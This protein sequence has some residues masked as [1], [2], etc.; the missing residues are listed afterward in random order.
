MV[1]SDIKLWRAS[2]NKEYYTYGAY[3]IHGELLY[4]GYGKGNRYQ[5]CNNG[6]SSNK[7]LNRYYFLNGENECIKLKNCLKTCL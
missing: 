3:G 6:M 4:I 7:G 5:H 1:L 2:M